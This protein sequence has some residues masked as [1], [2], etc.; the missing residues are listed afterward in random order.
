MRFTMHGTGKQKPGVQ[1]IVDSGGPS[2][3]AD[4]LPL[5]G[6][7]TAGSSSFSIELFM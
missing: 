6:P 3:L 1:S 5:L 7:R 2:G 4:V